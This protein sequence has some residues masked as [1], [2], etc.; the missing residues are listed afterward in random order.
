M[1]FGLRPHI[2]KQEVCFKTNASL[3]L[4]TL[5]FYSI[6]KNAKPRLSMKHFTGEETVPFARKNVRHMPG[7][8]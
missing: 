2:S 1:H 3:T 6:G 7:A 5:A 8:Y 4:K